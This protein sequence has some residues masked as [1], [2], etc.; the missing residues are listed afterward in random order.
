MTEMA[1]FNIQN[2]FTEGILR[3]LRSGFLTPDDYRRLGAAESLEDIRT[4]LDETDYG[5]FLQDEASLDINTIILKAKEKM[6]SE[7]AFLKSNSVDPLGKF[8]DFIAAEKMIDNVVILLQ[9][10]L[11]G[12]T[13]AELLLKA[14][15][16]GYFDEMRTIP[17]IDV[18]TGYEEIYR[19]V[20]SDTP[21][22]PYFA[23]FLKEANADGSKEDVGSILT[24]TDLELM[25][26]IVKKAWLEDFYAFAQEC[27]G[28]TAEIMSHILKVE[29]DFRV[30]NITL[31]SLNTSLGTTQKLGERNAMYPNFGY[32][33]P[34]GTEK[35]GK[36][37]N[38]T[39]VRAAL[40]PY[41]AYRELFDSVKMFYDK[42]AK[43]RS[44]DGDSKRKS[45]TKSMEDML[46][47]EMVKR[48]EE[49]FDQQFNYAVFYA[50]AKL[51]DQE[52]KNIA[53]I[54]NMLVMDKKEYV[55][56]IVPIFAP[57]N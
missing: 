11:N 20:L 7:F 43:N 5:S 30:L 33:F 55:D 56:D 32:L 10:A 25:K 6:A 38:Q 29:A 15:P 53:W 22:G 27:G 40:E 54:C 4:A 3:G 26:N 52:L 23:E 49:T 12:K 39:T 18:S 57:R 13:P 47:V 19:T 14:D 45:N 16:L 51:K 50:W 48:C 9:G 34:E 24:E 2:G 37:F 46:F 35:L 28:V 31:N 44:G 42:E 1:T 21:V 8:L 36:A 41:A 17:S